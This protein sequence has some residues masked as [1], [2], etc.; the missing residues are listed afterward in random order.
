[1][2]ML[3]RE[4]FSASLRAQAELG[5][6]LAADLLRIHAWNRHGL[7]VTVRTHGSVRDGGPFENVYIGV[8]LCAGDQLCRYVT[9]N[10]ADADRALARFEQLSK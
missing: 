9:F 5:P 2:G 1:M 8:A 7:V 4:Q 6:G 10:L 3:D